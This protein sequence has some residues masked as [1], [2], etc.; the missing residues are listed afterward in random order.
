MAR[1]RAQEHPLHSTTSCEQQF[2]T[3]TSEQNSQSMYQGECQGFK[4]SGTKTDVRVKSYIFWDITPCILLST[5]VS[6]EHIVSIFRVE[7]ISCPR[8]QRES[9]WQAE[10]GGDMFFRNVG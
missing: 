8:N 1:S 5:D 9:R 10:D 4:H 3:I 6:E 2:I 7:K